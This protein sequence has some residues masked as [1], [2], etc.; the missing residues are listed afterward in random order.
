MSLSVKID[1]S[2]IVP[3]LKYISKPNDDLLR[4]IGGHDAAKRTYA[5]ARRF[6]NTK[7]PIRPFWKKTL[8]QL[9]KKDDLIPKVKSALQYLYNEQDTFDT[10]LKN[11]WNYFPEGT[12]LNCR[13]F[14][15]LGYDIGIVSEGHALI[16]LGHPLFEKDPRE[17]FHMAMHE[18][19]HVVYTAYN[20]IFDPS[21]IRTTKQ[22]TEMIRYCT[23]MEGL[24]VYASLAP[25]KAAD[26]LTHEDYKIFLNKGARNQR[27]NEFFNHLTR[28]E[29]RLVK[30]V[31]KEDWRTIDKMSGGKRLWYIAGAHMAEV[32]DKN[33]GREFLNET[34]RHGPDEFF[35]A[36]HESF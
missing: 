27:V 24:A 21:A 28:L 34:I 17:I 29:T 26:A 30:T 19:H 31:K 1:T 33:L 10:L 11:L 4:E 16:N 14:T 36:Y 22:L 18:L 15:I 5:H 2:F 8:K 12:A 32:I 13:L 6:G 9:A 20:S 25:R 7:D 35:K 3:L 23:H